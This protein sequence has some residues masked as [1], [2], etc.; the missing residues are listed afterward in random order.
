MLPLYELFSLQR[1]FR[2]RMITSTPATLTLIQRLLVERRSS[3]RFPCHLQA[4]CH[5]SGTTWSAS[6]RSISTR[7]VGLVANRKVLPG[8][9]LIVELQPDSGGVP[10][11]AE[12]SVLRVQPEC[13]NEWL[14]GCRFARSATDE[15]LNGLLI[16]E[17]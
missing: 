12:V 16:E 15:E 13:E 5:Q 11:V 14:L 17:M 6:V 9:V 10:L 3:L 7:G 2:G 1:A 8:T 4:T